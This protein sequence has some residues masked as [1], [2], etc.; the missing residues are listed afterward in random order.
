MQ[1]RQPSR[2]A[3]STAGESIK[4]L[5]GVP[6]ERSAGPEDIEEVEMESG[7]PNSNTLNMSFN[8]EKSPLTYFCHYLYYKIQNP[9]L[10]FQSR[11][12]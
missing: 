6:K 5:K 11:L 9:I 2:K 1:V 7:E 4:R 12:F 10:I 8:S 3:S